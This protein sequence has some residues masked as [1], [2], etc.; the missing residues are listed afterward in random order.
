MNKIPF[1][2][3]VLLL[4]SHAVFAQKE[5]SEWTL[6][7]AI[8]SG[9]CNVVCE[10]GKAFYHRNGKKADVCLEM[11][12]HR[13]FNCSDKER[14]EY[15]RLTEERVKETNAWKSRQKAGKRR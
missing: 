15:N 13:P 14:A 11:R 9:E 6:K 10:D 4:A 1:M 12:K 5:S 3:V 2:L 7:E 8:E